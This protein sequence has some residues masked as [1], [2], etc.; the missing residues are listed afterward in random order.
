VTKIIL[1]LKKAIAYK[2]TSL[3]PNW[4]MISS[5][6]IFNIDEDISTSPKGLSGLD[7][8]YILY[9]KSFPCFP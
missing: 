2:F 1:D 4:G 9:I 7:A 3:N 8:R 6:S 5:L